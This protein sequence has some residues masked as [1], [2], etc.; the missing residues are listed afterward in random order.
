MRDHLSKIGAKG[1]AEQ[2][3]AAKVLGGVNGAKA[4]WAD[5]KICPACGRGATPEQ[6][7]NGTAIP[8]H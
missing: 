4:R 8:A 2:P 7:E 5:R 3:R 6:I 1:A